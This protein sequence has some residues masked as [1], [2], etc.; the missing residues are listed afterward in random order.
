MHNGVQNMRNYKIFR[1]IL[2]MILYVWSVRCIKNYMLEELAK[3]NTDS[4]LAGFLCSL[5][6][7]FPNKLYIITYNLL[8][9]Y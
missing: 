4:V 8:I 9:Y 7:G 2:S 6:S 1:G 5:N 3:A